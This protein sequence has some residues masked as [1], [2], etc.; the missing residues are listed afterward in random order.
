[1]YVN[2]KY[3]LVLL[4]FIQIISCSKNEID[5]EN[6]SELSNK[7]N[8]IF[9]QLNSGYESKS[10]NWSSFINCWSRDERELGSTE[11]PLLNVVSLNKQA[12]DLFSLENS[13]HNL[14]NY[15]RSYIDFIKEYIAMGGVFV[16]P[17]GD[18]IGFFDPNDVD[19]I[20]AI[21]PSISQIDDEWKIESKDN[22]YY[23]YGVNQDTSSGRNSYLD[24]ALVLGRFGSSEY[25]LI[26]IYPNS[27]TLDGESE[28]AILSHSYEFRTPSFAEMVRQLA[29]HATK[30]LSSLPPYP[31]VD[32]I[33]SCAN[34]I[35]LK[36]VW[37]R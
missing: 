36:N 27:T 37:W 24:K 4:V 35:K 9:P 28:S 3:S 32:L 26:L 18:E 23:R 20:Q 34:E 13:N 6:N 15:S 2:V 12:S 30:N 33:N 25:E 10:V 14:E 16:D 22:E 5:M 11:Q 19:T 21:A 29:F 31:Q 17:E 7:S 1:M 8:L